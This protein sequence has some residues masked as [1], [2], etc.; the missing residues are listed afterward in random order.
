VWEK[1]KRGDV[2]QSSF[3]FS[4]VAEKFSDHE[5]GRLREVLDTDLYDV[6][7]VTYPAYE[8]T[9]VQARM[10]LA[11]AGDQHATASASAGP[12]QI[13]AMVAEEQARRM[14]HNLRRQRL[15]ELTVRPRR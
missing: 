14:A 5:G 8:E 2:S 13:D 11:F 3:A 7:P 15:A 6:S 4:I 1:I 9:E 10:R 12:E